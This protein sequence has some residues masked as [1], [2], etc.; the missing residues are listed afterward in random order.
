MTLGMYATRIWDRSPGW[1]CSGRTRFIFP[2]D[3]LMMN[4]WCW[5]LIQNFSRKNAP[6]IFFGMFFLIKKSYFFQKNSSLCFK[7]FPNL[8]GWSLF[9]GS[10]SVEQQKFPCYSK[11]GN[12]S[13]SLG[14]LQWRLESKWFSKHNVYSVPNA[15]RTVLKGK[16]ERIHLFLK[17][18]MCLWYVSWAPCCKYL[19]GLL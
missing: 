16:K 11:K 3:L 7:T 19:G 15:I 2:W 13:R 14:R 12:A 4:T 9:W 5:V 18:L 8:L 1:R 6:L 17:Q 10:G